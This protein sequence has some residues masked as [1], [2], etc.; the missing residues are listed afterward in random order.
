MEIENTENSSSAPPT[1]VY[2]RCG[3]SINLK[4]HRC[5]SRKNASQAHSRH[6]EDSPGS[7]AARKRLI[8]NDEEADG[9]TAAGSGDVKRRKLDTSFSGG[10]TA[11]AAGTEAAT[12]GAEGIVAPGEDAA[13]DYQPCDDHTEQK[14]DQHEEEQEQA[15]K[16]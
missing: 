4:N 1:V 8:E 6:E 14:Y 7:A 9:A 3:R 10:A 12:C 15:R 5:D 13:G 11:G 16:D 2:R